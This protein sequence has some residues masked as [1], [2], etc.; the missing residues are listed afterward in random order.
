MVKVVDIPYSDAVLVCDT[1]SVLPRM[2]H[3][4]ALCVSHR[5]KKLSNLVDPSPDNIHI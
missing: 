4:L 3:L 2:D 1:V 5:Y